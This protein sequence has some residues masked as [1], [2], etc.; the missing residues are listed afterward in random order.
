[1][2]APRRLWLVRHALPMVAPGICYGR[3]DLAADPQD[4]A[5]AAAALADALPP[6]CRVST[7][8]LRRCLELA[9]ALER[10]RPD[11]IATP[12]PR[13]AEMD[14][15]TWEGR[16]WADL[17]AETLDAWTADFAGHAPGGGET[18]TAFMAR[19][20]SALADTAA[21]DTAWLTHAGVIRAASLVVRGLPDAITAADWPSA[22]LG[23]G[24]LTR[25]DLA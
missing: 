13:L 16:A 9:G 12:D 3:L 18:V 5:R 17:G 21:G 6:A 15:G 20:R 23:F 24:S 2:A 14:F 1:M 25:L 11:L 8:P 19:V 4:T 10:L 7:S 22:H